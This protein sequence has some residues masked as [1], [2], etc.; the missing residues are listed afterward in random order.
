MERSNS[1]INSFLDMDGVKHSHSGFRYLVSAIDIGIQSPHGLVKVLEIY[2]AVA[3]MQCS[4][5]V[6]VERTIRYS[7]QGTKLTSKEFI[8]RAIDLNPNL[9]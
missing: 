5:S 9:K 6:R 3:E 1:D 4:T 7:I 8:F 2:N